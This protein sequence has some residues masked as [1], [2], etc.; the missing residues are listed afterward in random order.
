[1]NVVGQRRE[2]PVGVPNGEKRSWM[3]NVGCEVVSRPYGDGRGRRS[4]VRQRRMS[5]A[6]DRADV[7]EMLNQRYGRVG[8][9]L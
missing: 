3:T 4:I 1:M 8:R 5:E 9:L 2:E 7:L 6:V